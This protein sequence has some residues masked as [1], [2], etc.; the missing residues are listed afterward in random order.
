MAII[1][2]IFIVFLEI[3]YCTLF[4]E[5]FLER[6]INKY[7]FIKQ[8]GL[9][10]MT[11]AVV[12]ISIELNGNIALKELITILFVSSTMLGIYKSRIMKMLF[13]ISIYFGILLGIDYLALTTIK[14]IIPAAT[15]TYLDNPI[16]GTIFVLL[17]KTLVFVAIMVIKKNWDI[18]NSLSLLS[19]SQWL[20]FIYF[21]IMSIIALCA[22]LINF[23]K[24]ISETASNTLLIIAFGLVIMN[25]M[26]F[27]LMRDIIGREKLIQSDKIFKERMKNQTN[28]YRSMSD[29]FEIQRKRIHEYN[30]QIGCIEGMLLN[31][32][33]EQALDYVVKITGGLKKEINAIDTNNVIINAIINS[34]YKEAID[35]NIVMVIKVNDLSE[36]VIVDEDIVIILSNLLNNAIEA[37]EKIIEKRIIWLK[38]VIEENM[39]IISVKNTAEEDV[40]IIDGA[41]IT[42]KENKTEH[43]LGV[44]N[45]KESVEKYKG[46]YTLQGQGGYFFFGIIIPIIA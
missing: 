45:I 4:L 43:G 11:L 37:C 10:F 3:L 17:C 5:I 1:Q 42:T 33:V 31:K 2:A 8:Y 28:M 39:T 35:K 27:Y 30:N 23:D 6:R 20:R 46:S 25:L 36:C 26:V 29:D 44:K 7:K 18:N 9:I 12:I 21:P 38:F 32:N 41:L 13:L 24:E 40:E 16:Y 34:K 14:Y 19:D 22:M 15:I